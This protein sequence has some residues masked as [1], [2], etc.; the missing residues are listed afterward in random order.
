MYLIVP[1]DEH[2]PILQVRPSLRQSG[3]SESLLQSQSIPKGCPF[4]PYMYSIDLPNDLIEGNAS[5]VI[6]LSDIDGLATGWTE[7]V[8]IVFP[9]PSILNVSTPNY[10]K[11]GEEVQIEFKVR[12]SDDLNNVVCYI[13]VL[14]KN[15]TILY[16]EQNPS[17][18]GEIL[19]KWTP[20]RPM[21]EVNISIICEDGM[22]R[23]DS[24]NSETP[25]NITGTI[26]DKPP[27]I[28]EDED[29]EQSSSS[30]ILAIVIGLGSIFLI[31]SSLFVWIS[32]RENEIELSPWEIGG[33][34]D[35]SQVESNEHEELDHQDVVDLLRNE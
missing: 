24:W 20:S 31:V 4:S 19:V 34:L 6:I 30:G 3:W 12:D 13:D 18:E 28:V 10:G 29:I 35:V 14:N 9:P 2:R 22:K 32:R 1:I 27:E 26:V 15:S 11:V 16:L 23:F 7:E 21:E 25:M 5:I 17:L 33:V 8:R